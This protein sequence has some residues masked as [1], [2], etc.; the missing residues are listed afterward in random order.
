LLLTHA[1]EALCLVEPRVDLPD[2]VLTR[3][4]ARREER[5]KQAVPI[6]G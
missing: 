2:R 1:R 3:G 6:H 5:L 4:N